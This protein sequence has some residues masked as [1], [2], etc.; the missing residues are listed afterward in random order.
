MNQVRPQWLG[1]DRFALAPDWSMSPPMATIE[2]GQR[3]R[4]TVGIVDS[5]PAGCTY[6]FQSP[7]M[8]YRSTD[9]AVVAAVGPA[10]FEGVAPGTAR[11]VVDNLTTPSGRT[12]TVELTVCSQASAPE[13]TCP[14]RVPLVI[15]VVP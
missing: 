13:I 7:Q 10:L 14:S 1:S 8:S 12:E 15:R 6:G 11:V 3:F 2:V 4:V 9:A 5:R